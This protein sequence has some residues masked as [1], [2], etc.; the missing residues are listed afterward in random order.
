M[1]FLGN[2]FLQIWM[3]FMKDVPDTNEE[4]LYL[5]RWVDEIKLQASVRSIRDGLAS[6]VQYNEILTIYL[7]METMCKHCKRRVWYGGCL[8]V[9]QG[10]L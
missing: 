5:S 2:K 9:C 4:K 10:K 3:E 6:L 1:P 7:Q 8:F